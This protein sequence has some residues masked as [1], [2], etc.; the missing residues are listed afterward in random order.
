MRRTKLD[1]SRDRQGA[2][3][4]TLL[5]FLA[6]AAPSWANSQEH[7]ET[8]VRPLLAE[9]CFACH[10]DSAL[11]GLRLDSREA[12]LQGGARGPAG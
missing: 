9:R 7:F 1:P 10:A 12:M 3:V 4:A 2:V 6:L 5:L 8:R 11:G